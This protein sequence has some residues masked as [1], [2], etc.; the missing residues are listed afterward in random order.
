MVLSVGGLGSGGIEQEEKST[1]GHQCGDCCGGEIRGLNGKGKKY[2][3][4]E[5]IKPIYCLLL[6]WFLLL[7]S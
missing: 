2:N 3:N 7:L 6:L 5:K 4:H 1:H